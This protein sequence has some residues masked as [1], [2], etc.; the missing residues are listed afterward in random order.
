MVKELE[1]DVLDD[2]NVDRCCV[3]VCRFVLFDIEREYETDIDYEW[4]V[5]ARHIGSEENRQTHILFSPSIYFQL[6]FA[7]W[8]TWKTPPALATSMTVLVGGTAPMRE[9]IDGRAS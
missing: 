6:R 8:K 7:I 9:C 5:R 3:A 2:L 4:S 1:S